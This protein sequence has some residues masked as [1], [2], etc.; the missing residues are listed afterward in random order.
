MLPR[1]LF[2]G[3]D[4]KGIDMKGFFAVV[5]FILVLF[6]GRSSA[7]SQPPFL[8]DVGLSIRQEMGRYL[9]LDQVF[10]SG[11]NARRSFEQLA[12][13]LDN[14]IPAL[15]NTIRQM[16][17]EARLGGISFTNAS[18]SIRLDLHETRAEN[19]VAGSR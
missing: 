17:G 18:H 2:R 12:K 19:H 5:T 9:A 4:I 6:L 14:A 8:Q 1:L 11:A 16:E 3:R 13:E 15:L 10:E 7:A